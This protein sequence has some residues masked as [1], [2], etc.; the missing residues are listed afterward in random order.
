MIKRWNIV[1][2][3]LTALLIIGCGQDNT[4]N[5]ERILSKPPYA[6]IT[7]SIKATPQNADLYLVRAIR[8][9]QNNQHE[10]ATRDYEKAWELAPAESTAL[11]YVSNLLLVDQPAEAVKLLKACIE[12]YPASTE[13]RRR[14][15]EVY[16]QVGASEEALEQY[17][18]LLEKDSLNFET[19]FEK[20]TLLVQLKDTPD[21]IKAMERSYELQ[22]INYTGLA[23]ANLYAATLNPKTLALCDELIS[24][25]TTFIN[26]AIFLKGTYYSDTKQY[27]LALEQFEECIKRNWKFTDAYIEKGIVLYEQKQ[28]PEALEVFGIAATVSNTNADAYYWIAR[29]YEATGRKDQ[30]LQNYQRALAF[31]KD[32]IEAR[33][34]IKRL[35]G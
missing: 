23:L 9:S 18:E 32:F 6:G 5:P 26:E 17:N 11:Q 12:K 15:S 29:C 16:A 20:G 3:C 33:E 30:A 1:G 13:F 10:L 7:D 35:K 27:A 25:D 4:E 24:K 14:L 21:A 8:L 28:Y 19:W 2:Y 34:A 22:P 31:D